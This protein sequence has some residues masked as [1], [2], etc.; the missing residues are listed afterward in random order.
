MPTA[1]DALEG[2][3]QPVAFMSRKLT[4]GQRKWVPREQETYTILL[5][6]MKWET[7]IGLQPVLV[8][9][10]HKTIQSWTKEILDVP[11]GPVGRRGRWHEYLSRYDLTVEYIPG[12]DNVVADCLSRWAYPASVAQRDI[13]M[14][15]NAKDDEEMV[16]LIRHEKAEER[17]CFEASRTSESSPLSFCW[18]SLKDP[19]LHSNAWLCGREGR[20]VALAERFTAECQ[21]AHVDPSDDSDSTDSDANVRPVRFEFKRKQNQTQPAATGSPDQGPP[22]Q[23]IKSVGRRNN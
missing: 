23:P 18:I 12:K 16:D 11:S 20:P 8:L 22:P 4:E 7:C 10:D 15:G 21:L 17:T 2:R 19:P 9:T 5:A 1:Q 14:H 3:T 6:L 13:S